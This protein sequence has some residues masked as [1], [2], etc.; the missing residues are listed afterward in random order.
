M[1]RDE[2]GTGCNSECSVHAYVWA[3][4]QEEAERLWNTRTD[5]QRDRLVETLRGLVEAMPQETCDQDCTPENCL[6][7]EARALL[8]EEE[9]RHD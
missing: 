2:W 1:D 5:P 8:A 6:R 9:K 3:K 7:T 4:T